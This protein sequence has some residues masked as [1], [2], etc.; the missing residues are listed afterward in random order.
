MDVDNPIKYISQALNMTQQRA[1]EI[2][3][4]CTRCTQASLLA[5]EIT[6]YPFYVSGCLEFFTRNGYILTRI[7]YL[8]GVK[9]KS[10]KSML[11]MEKDLFI[12]TYRHALAIVDRILIDTEQKGFDSRKI[13]Y[14]WEVTK[15][16]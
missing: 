13:L 12:I 6:G 9:M 11:F 8:S 10:L 5:Y 3:N 14:A 2:V 16:G 15:V 1:D 4:I 7:P